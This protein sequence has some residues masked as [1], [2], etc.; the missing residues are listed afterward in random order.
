VAGDLKADA[1]N[2]DLTLEAIRG[3]VAARTD[4]GRIYARRIGGRLDAETGNGDVELSEVRWPA[5]ARSANGRVRADG[6][7]A[8][9]KEVALSSG[10]GDLWFAGRAGGLTAETQSGSVQA[11]LMSLPRRTQLSSG[12]GDVGCRVPQGA[13]VEVDA[14]TG[15][16][17]VDLGHLA[18]RGKAAR[19]SSSPGGAE[20]RGRVGAGGS[21]LKAHTASGGIRLGE[22]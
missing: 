9:G 12:N 21:F 17:T 16:G 13:D 18:T 15:N 11:E 8:A 14:S 22:L 4:S 10:N 6:V 5:R 20:W 1:G 19:G 7:T 3:A 2:G